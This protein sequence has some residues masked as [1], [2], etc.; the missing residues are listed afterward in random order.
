MI[1]ATIFIVVGIALFLFYDQYLETDQK[2]IVTVFSFAGIYASLFGLVVM[3]VQ[4][5]S[6]KMTA[7]E[8]RDKIDNMASIAELSKL[9]ALMRDAATDIERDQFALARYK[10]Q[11][12][13]DA[14]ISVYGFT[15]QDANKNSKLQEIVKRLN[16]DISS[17]NESILV[18]NK[19]QE[20]TESIK[21]GL[22]ETVEFVTD[23][24]QGEIHIQ[25]K[26]YN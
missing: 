4:F 9:T 3:L 22:L 16:S 21:P 19:D 12:T 10:F 18:V 7:I 14:I 2:T 26:N 6:V 11:N 13:K 15:H 5:R 20:H 24:L 23:F 25:K 17:L 1:W 8:T